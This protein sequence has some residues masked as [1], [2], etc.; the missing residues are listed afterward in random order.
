M[1]CI[2]WFYYI[3]ICGSWLIFV[4][5]TFT[6]DI[7]KVPNVEGDYLYK[8]LEKIS[9]KKL[10]SQVSPKYSNTYPEGVVFDQSP[11]SVSLVKRGRTVFLS[12]SLGEHSKSLPDFRGYTLF[13]LADFLDKTYINTKIPYT[14]ETPIYEFN[15]TVEKGR[16]IKQDPP[17]GT[18]LREVKK[19]KLWISNGIKDQ[20]EKVLPNFVGKKFNEISK[21]IEELEIFYN[22]NFTIVNKK[23]EDM[24]ITAQSI[25]EGAL[26]SEIIEETKP[27][28]FSV[29][30][31]KE[32]NGEKIEG[33]LPLTLPKKPF[34]F[35]FEAKIKTIKDAKEKILFNIKTKGGVE[36]PIPYYQ[37]DNGTLYIYYNN[38]LEKEIIIKDAI[39]EIENK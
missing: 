30:I 32:I 8:A 27:V 19:V 26:I 33:F 24:L 23:D 13:D 1:V 6:T 39:K 18:P 29:N 28:I 5:F 31:Y 20:T 2:L 10:V 16:I 17:D 37:K 14:F 11:S 25:G 7:V 36:I 34:P 15:D 38:K 4:L 9:E 35:R 21:E 12:V 22:I 3:N